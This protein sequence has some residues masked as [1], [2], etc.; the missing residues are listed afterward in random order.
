MVRNI[1]FIGKNILILCLCSYFLGA[2]NIANKSANTSVT[3]PKK[4]EMFDWRIFVGAG[5]VG[6]LGRNVRVA[7]TTPKTFY[8]PTSSDLYYNSTLIGLKG[9]LGTEFIFKDGNGF[10]I[11]FEAGI[12]EVAFGANY[13]YELRGSYKL[14]FMSGLDIG[15]FFDG[16]LHPIK[17]VIT[18]WNLGIRYRENKHAL[19]LNIKVPLYEATV[20]S[21]AIEMKEYPGVGISMMYSYFF[22][23]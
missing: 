16:A 3:T 6:I 4:E 15:K 11:L 1:N 10:N 8:S 12:P 23:I 13:V 19:G 22:K 14:A 5:F 21:P 18:S 7:S 20:S 2:E 9:F 17:G